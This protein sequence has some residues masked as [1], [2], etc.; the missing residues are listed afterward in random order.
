MKVLPI[1]LA[2]ANKA[3]KKPTSEADFWQQADDDV[4]NEDASPSSSK[5]VEVSTWLVVVTLVVCKII[6][7]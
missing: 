4:D 3:A 2:N 5:E 1:R 6:A 7:K